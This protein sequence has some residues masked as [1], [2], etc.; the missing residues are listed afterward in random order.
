MVVFVDRLSGGGLGLLFRLRARGPFWECAGLHAGFPFLNLRLGGGFCVCWRLRWLGLSL[1]GGEVLLQ[2]WAAA[3][4][5]C[6]IPRAVGAVP[7]VA[8]EVQ[9]RVFARTPEA[10]RLLRPT[11]SSCVS[12]FSAMPTQH[13]AA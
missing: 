5:R 3:L 1:L 2:H 11:V 6:V 13:E 8:V 7:V 10:A 4:P 9:C 12:I